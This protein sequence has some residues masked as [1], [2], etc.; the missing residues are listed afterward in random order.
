[1][2]ASYNRNQKNT[3]PLHSFVLEST[4]YR[5]RAR[6]LSLAGIPVSIQVGQLSHFFILLHQQN[7]GSGPQLVFIN[8]LTHTHTQM[9]ATTY[10]PWCQI[11]L[12]LFPGL[13]VP[14]SSF[15][16][17]APF[18]HTASDHKLEGE[19]RPWPHRHSHVCRK[20]PNPGQNFSP[21]EVYL[22]FKFSWAPIGLHCGVLF[23]WYKPSY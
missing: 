6:M 1:M 15:W 8:T 19:T 20:G 10:H 14:P 13:K 9:L 5:K 22:F 7:P 12:A 4:C 21:H 23:A 3:F 16:S 2:A 18:L 11:S 17:L